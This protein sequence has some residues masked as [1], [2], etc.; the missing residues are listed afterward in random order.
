MGREPPASLCRFLEIAERHSM[1]SRNKGPRPLSDPLLVV[2]DV[3]AEQL[4][5]LLALPLAQRVQDSLV[6]T[7]PLL[8]L[9]RE[10]ALAEA[11][12]M[13][14]GSSLPSQDLQ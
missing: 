10:E 13:S 14:P 4:L 11:R 8:P 7:D 3:G 12:F 5:R 6:G 9:P 1:I 2:G